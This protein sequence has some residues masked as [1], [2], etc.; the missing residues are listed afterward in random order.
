MYTK[1]S[2]STFK[3]VE[4]GEGRYAVRVLWACWSKNHYLD[5]KCNTFVWSE[6]DFYFSD[7]LGTKEECEATMEKLS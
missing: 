5:L 1:L 7:C 2:D 6:G 3:V 4:M